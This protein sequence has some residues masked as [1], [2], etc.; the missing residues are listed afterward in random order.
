MTKP[1][2]G[3][4]TKIRL[5][6]VVF[7][8]II[9][10]IHKFYLE[11]RMGVQTFSQLWMLHVRSNVWA[12]VV[13]M[14]ISHACKQ[15]HKGQSDTLRRTQMWT[16][17]THLMEVVTFLLRA[18]PALVTCSLH[19]ITAGFFPLLR[20]TTGPLGALKWLWLHWA[21]SP[22]PFLPVIRR[23]ASLLPAADPSYQIW[24]LQERDNTSD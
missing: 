10:W 23:H 3:L 11:I 17:V 18:V 24:S 4:Q 5:A 20:Q 12:N 14:S 8:L 15:G 19:W 16:C 2:V 22:P 1:A 13:E 6:W 9:K 7:P 21:D